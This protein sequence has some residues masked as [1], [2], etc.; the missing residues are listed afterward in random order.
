MPWANT[1][2]L[3]EKV[4]FYRR[5]TTSDGYGN[6]TGGWVLLSGPWAARIRPINGKEEILA[7]KLAGVQPVEI[8]VRSCAATRTITVADRAVNART[9]AVYDLTAIQNPDERNIWLAMLAKA[10]DAESF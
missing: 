6:Q 2:Q 3:R 4:S 7:A 9:G 5:S 8:V 1:G 10:G